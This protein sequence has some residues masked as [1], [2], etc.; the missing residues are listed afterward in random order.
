M[1]SSLLISSVQIFTSKSPPKSPLLSIL[2]TDLSLGSHIEPEKKI[3][4][5]KNNNNNNIIPETLNDLLD[6]PT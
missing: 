6:S 5:L 3:W 1:S 2:K 4:N